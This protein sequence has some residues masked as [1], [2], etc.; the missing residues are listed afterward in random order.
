MGWGGCGG[1]GTLRLHHL[2]SDLS[3]PS[4]TRGDSREPLISQGSHFLEDVCSGSFA[5]RA[6]KRQEFNKRSRT[7]SPIRQTAVI[8]RRSTLY[9]ADPHFAA[10]RGAQIT[11]GDV[12]GCFKQSN[13]SFELCGL[14]VNQ[15]ASNPVRLVS[16]SFGG[17]ANISDIFVVSAEPFLGCFYFLK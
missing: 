12:L 13:R 2:A 1:V 7:P 6:P 5:I 16:G 17:Q 4:G 15:E 3:Q 14:S 8:L 11:S 9:E 10:S